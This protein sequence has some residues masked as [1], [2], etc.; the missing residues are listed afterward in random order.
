MHGPGLFFRLE[1]QDIDSLAE[2]KQIIMAAIL[3]HYLSFNL[4]SRASEANFLVLDH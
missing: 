3:P 2:G 1:A 4:A